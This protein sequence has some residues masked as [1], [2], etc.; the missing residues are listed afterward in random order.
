MVNVYS[1]VI[2]KLVF[3]KAVGRF[4]TKKSCVKRT[5]SHPTLVIEDAKECSKARAKAIIVEAKKCFAEHFARAE[6]EAFEEEEYKKLAM[7]PEQLQEYLEKKA[8]DEAIY[9]KWWLSLD[10]KDR[11][12]R[13]RRQKRFA[14]DERDMY[15]SRFGHCE[16]IMADLEQEFV[17][18]SCQ[19]SMSFP[20]EE[21]KTLPKYVCMYVLCNENWDSYD[22]DE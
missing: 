13:E 18:L 2:A 15:E 11:E 21:C 10:A 19:S 6:Q 1:I 7:V 3:K 8:A 20:Y 5:I 16:D 17:E 9:L 22:N 4:K 14:R 12:F